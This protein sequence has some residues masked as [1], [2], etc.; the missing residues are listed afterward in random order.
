M[1][2]SQ[3]IPVSHAQNKSGD[4]I[5]RY[6]FSERIHHWIAGLSY[7][8]CLVTGLAFWSPYLYWMAALAGS[9]PTARFWHPWVGLVFTIST[10]WMYKLWR[11]DMATTEADIAWKKA[12]RHYIRNE[13]E[14]LPAVG[15]FNYGQKL[16]FWLMFYGA[17]VLVLS[18]I[19]LWFVE[20]IPWSLRWLR[21]LAV[22]VHVGTALVTIGAFIIHVYMGTA[23]VRGSFAAM[24]RGYVSSAW[25]RTHHRLWYEQVTKA[26]SSEK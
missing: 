15:R 9:G 7:L 1:S 17:I 24:V 13:D 10:L 21:Y 2:A 8:Y 11:R 22:T 6:T 4:R 16:F 5:L 18:G 3:A 19:G 14:K 25:A 26:T 12:M 20:S 23:M